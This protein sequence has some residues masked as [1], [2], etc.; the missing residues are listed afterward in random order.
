MEVTL[1]LPENIE[2]SELTSVKSLMASVIEKDRA[3][4]QAQKRKE[5]IE[6]EEN[7]IKE[8]EKLAEIVPV[9]E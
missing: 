6:V 2:D 9:N 3:A 7:K 1:G 8:P 4:I 5:A